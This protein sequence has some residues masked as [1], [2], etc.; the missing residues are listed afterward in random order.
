MTSVRIVEEYRQV[1]LGAIARA[2]TAVLSYTEQQAIIPP[3][4]ARLAYRKEQHINYIIASLRRQN[5]Q[6]NRH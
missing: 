5:E 3:Y 2:S 1:P 4:R 6:C